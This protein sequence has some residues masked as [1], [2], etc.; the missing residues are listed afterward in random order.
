MKNK[1]FTLVELLAVVAILAVIA[2]ITIPIVTKTITNSKNSTSDRQKEQIEKA[3]Q[4]WFIK[5]YGSLK[6]DET[7]IVTVD[8][9]K[10]DGY[11]E[12]SEIESIKTGNPMQG[13]VKITYRSN[14]YKYELVETEQSNDSR[15]DC[16]STSCYKES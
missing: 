7:L 5:E 8:R 14:Q 16:S 15:C 13:C 9:I 6:E 2:L 10:S 4:T 12:Q 11:I 3:A 1:G